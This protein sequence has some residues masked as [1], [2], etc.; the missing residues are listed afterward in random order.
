MA[1]GDFKGTIDFGTGPLTSAGDSDLFVASWGACG[2]PLWARRFGDSAAQTMKALAISPSGDPVVTG[3]FAGS[4]VFGRSSLQGPGV[5]AAR[6]TSNATADVWSRV[7][8]GTPGEDIVT[9]ADATTDQ[10]G[11]TTLVGYMD[12]RIDFGG[13]IITGQIGGWA[14]HL[15]AAGR[16]QWATALPGGSD[17]EDVKVLT[18]PD[19]RTYVYTQWAT[20]SRSF[21]TQLAA[22]GTVAFN[23]RYYGTGN[24]LEFAY[25]MAFAPDGTLLVAG[26][27]AFA[28]APVT[29]D[30][31]ERP[32]VANLDASGNPLWVRKLD[33]IRARHITSRARTILIAG[34]TTEG[35]C[36]DLPGNDCATFVSRLATDGST[37]WANGLH[38]PAARTSA[39]TADPSGNPILTGTFDTSL[40]AGKFQLTGA[41]ATPFIASFSR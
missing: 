41:A 5:F 37:I 27:G 10:R 36:L 35:S 8:A 15:D 6:L 12:G 25:D 38:G 40:K 32:F 24:Q 39:L 4:L 22:D 17:R 16:T 21:L 33:G 19:Q 30:A 13:K 1:A 23:R 7:L 34:E 14:A 31:D 28:T 9:V 26:A 3:H 20:G 2:E 29:G 11:E 18:A